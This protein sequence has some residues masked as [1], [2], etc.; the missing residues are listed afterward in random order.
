MYVDT[1]SL[2]NLDGVRF[3]Y[4]VALNAGPVFFTMY[5]KKLVIKNSLFVGNF[6]LEKGGC[7]Y[8]YLIE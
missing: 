3:E 1:N 7:F 2:I 4:N 6:A 8:L 5:C